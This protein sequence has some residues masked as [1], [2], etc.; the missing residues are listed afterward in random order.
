MENLPVIA[1][2]IFSRRSPLISLLKRKIINSQGFNLAVKNDKAK[3][4]SAGF[5]QLDE[6]GFNF[7]LGFKSIHSFFPCFSVKAFN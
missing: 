4:L 1:P 7:L 5:S 2:E 3:N 6:S